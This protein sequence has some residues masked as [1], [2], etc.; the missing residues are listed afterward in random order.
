MVL[1]VQALYAFFKSVFALPLIYYMYSV[2]LLLAA[3]A[4]LVV[5]SPNILE[6]RQFFPG[7]S[8]VSSTAP[9]GDG[10]AHQN[11]KYTQVT[12]WPFFIP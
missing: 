5:A 12:V 1:R 6:D 2:M 8:P 10:N 11:Y 9:I 4:T 7:C 3:I